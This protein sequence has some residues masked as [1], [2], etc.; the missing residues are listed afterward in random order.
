MD[1]TIGLTSEELEKIL[2]EAGIKGEA[3]VSADVMRK[4]IAKTISENN[5][6]IVMQLLEMMGKLQ[7]ETLM[8]QFMK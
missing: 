6:S 5:A 8:K 2:E 1:V 7:I 4:A 3:P